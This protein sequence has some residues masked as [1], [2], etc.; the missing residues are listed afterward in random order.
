VVVA[1]LC[2]EKKYVE[3][4][5]VRY[6]E[7]ATSRDSQERRRQDGIRGWITVAAHNMVARENKLYAKEVEDLMDKTR[8]YML[9][10]ILYS[11]LDEVILFVA[12]SLGWALV[13]FKVLNFEGTIG[14][15]TAFLGLWNALMGPINYFKSFFTDLMETLTDMVRLKKLMEEEPRIQDGVTGL[16]FTKGQVCLENITSTYPGSKKVIVTDLSL[17]IEGGSKVAFVGPSGTGKSTLL[18]LVSR[19][20]LP[21][22]GRIL[23]DS[24]DIALLSKNS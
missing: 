19:L 1:Y 4:Y 22:K 16:A 13:S 24:Q 9:T 10:N 18:K 3:A 15:L 8:S 7:Y 2:A 11:S 21:T 12:N 6:S 14:S 23:I 17:T 5:L 20:L